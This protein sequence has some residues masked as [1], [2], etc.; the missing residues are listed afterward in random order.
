MKS[1]IVTRI[2]KIRLGAALLAALAPGLFAGT[3]AA[4]EVNL[5]SYRQPFLIE[6]ILAKFT[7]ETGIEV[8][9]VFAKKGMIDKIKAAGETIRRTRC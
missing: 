8:N 7:E 4:A 5:Y 1:T 6:P 3:V 9:V 2:G